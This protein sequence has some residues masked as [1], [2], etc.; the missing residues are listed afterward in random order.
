MLLL[1]IIMSERVET[2]ARSGLNGG[3]ENVKDI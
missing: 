3:S 1:E 2:K